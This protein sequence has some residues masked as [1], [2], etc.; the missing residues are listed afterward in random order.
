MLAPRIVLVTRKT[1]WRLLIE[2]HGTE[3]QARFVLGERGLPVDALVQADRI[4][5]EAV[6]RV[7]SSIPMAWRRTAI[8]RTGLDRFPFEPED[9]VIAVGQDGLVANVAKYLDGQLVIGVNSA[10]ERNAGVLVRHS[11]ERGVELMLAAGEGRASDVEARVLVEATLDDG[12]RLRGLNEIFVGH[13]SHQSARYTLQVG[14]E[15]ERHSSSG[16]LV[17]TGTGA[18]GWASS[19]VRNR[20]GAP[21]MPAPCEARLAWLVREAWSSPAT[22]CSLTDGA[23]AEG[24]VL[25]LT[26]ELERGGVVFADG[27]ETD[28]LRFDHGS[29]VAIGAAQQ[30]LHL[31]LG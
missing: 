27:I 23:L 29:S 6:H 13:H 24:Q 5:A 16:V 8:D 30:R 1:P 9:V 17:A 11:A 3:A 26:S 19:V 21:P 25:R 4:E 28:H 22:G 10:P 14:G 20:A 31:L 18:T 15:S 7:S 2:R 12:Q